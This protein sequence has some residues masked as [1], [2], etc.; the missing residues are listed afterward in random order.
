M[1][2]QEFLNI[3][4][5]IL[6]WRRPHGSAA[7]KA[8]LNW[9]CK[10][11]N[12][13]PT[14]GGV[15]RM[16]NQ[17]PDIWIVAHADTVGSEGRN[18]IVIERDF[19]KL[20]TPT[21]NQPNNLYCF[22]QCLG[23]DDGAGLA[24]IAMLALHRQDITLFVPVGEE[25]G[26]IGST[27]MCMSLSK[28]EMPK[29]VISLDRKGYNEVITHQGGVRTCS[30][31]FALELA[32]H[33]PGDYHPSNQGIY[34]DSATF[35]EFGSL[36][37]TNI[38]VGYFNAHSAKERVHWT[39]TYKLGQTMCEIPF[40]T[41]P[42]EH[43]PNN[44][45]EEEFFIFYENNENNIQEF[46]NIYEKETIFPHIFRQIMEIREEITNEEL[47]EELLEL[48]PEAFMHATCVLRNSTKKPKPISSKNLLE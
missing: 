12:F 10:E 4:V 29:I 27:R 16:G 44:Q 15:I 47:L 34:T 48:D 30:D 39:F 35:S 14:T 21:N 24:I 36:E 19:I 22:N 31:R 5:Q 8:V 9:F 43:S 26:G 28:E 23:A 33:L 3:L 20:K 41:L 25:S 42:I 7:E 32:K 38:S 40:H 11:F 17:Y 46:L 37:C 18:K 1:K 6:K 45:E 2:K 13:K